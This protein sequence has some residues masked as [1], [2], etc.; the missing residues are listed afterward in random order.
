MWSVAGA[1]KEGKPV[2]RGKRTI[3]HRLVETMDWSHPKDIQERIAWY[4]A[5]TDPE[6]LSMAALSSLAGL[7]HSVVRTTL[8][9]LEK[10]PEGCT[11]ATARCL[12][13]AMRVPFA[14]L[15][16]GV[17]HEA[18]AHDVRT[19][20]PTTPPPGPAP[21]RPPKSTRTPT[22]AA[23]LSSAQVRRAKTG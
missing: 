20:P 3:V 15:L 13:E 17:D 2:V 19:R 23:P 21:K 4:I 7:G 14:W 18:V 11:V 22:K 6:D 5:T 1:G 12:A 10:N 9:R 8:K 16:D